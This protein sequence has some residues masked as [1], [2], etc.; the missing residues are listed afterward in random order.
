MTTPCVAIFWGIRDKENRTVLLLDKTTIDRGEI[1]GE[2]VTHPTGHYEF[3]DGLSKLGAS[4]L[5]DRGLP[6]SPAW[7]EYEDFPRGRVV[8]RPRDKR[9]VIYAD[10]RLQTQKF[11]EQLVTALCIPDGSYVVRSDP[12]YRS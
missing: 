6:T 7:H 2:F 12:H 1:Y 10:R 8:Y 3:W 9:F 11:I 4:V 5:I